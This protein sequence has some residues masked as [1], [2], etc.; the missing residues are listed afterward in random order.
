MHVLFCAHLINIF[1]YMTGVE[2]RFVFLSEMLRGRLVYVI[3][4][5]NSIHSFIF[6]LCIM[7]DVHASPILCSF[8]NYFFLKLVEL[9][10]LI[11]H[12]FNMCTLYFVQ[13]YNIFFS[14]ELGQKNY[15]IYTTFGRCAQVQSRVWS[16][17]SPAAARS[18]CSQFIF[19]LFH[20]PAAAHSCFYLLLFIPPLSLLCLLVPLYISFSYYPLL[21]HCL[22]LL[23]T[24]CCC[25]VFFPFNL[26]S[27]LI[28]CCYCVFFFNSS[29]SLYPI[30]FPFNYWSKFK[31]N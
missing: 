11:V 26:L 22:V 9:C 14:V 3:C 15:Y 27:L 31:I 8:D 4:N 21:L 18:S 5:S 10:I 25:S 16:C 17:L 24:P 7:E 20:P 23:C 19:S 28:H 30:L 29:F 12:T 13:I 2:R 6:K 1:S